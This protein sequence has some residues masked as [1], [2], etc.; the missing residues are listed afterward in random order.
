MWCVVCGVLCV[1]CGGLC[2]VCSVRFVVCGVL[3]AVCCYS[4]GTPET[5][6]TRVNLSSHLIDIKLLQV[7]T[8]MLVRFCYG[9]T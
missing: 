9:M 7:I 3:Y 8:P 6:W 2:V 5:R 4:Y 1:V